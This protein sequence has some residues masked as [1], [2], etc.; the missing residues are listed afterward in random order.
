MVY[1]LAEHTGEMRSKDWSDVPTFP[2]TADSSGE[3]TKWV[4]P[5][6]FFDEL[7]DVLRTVAP[8]PGEQTL[9]VQ[10]AAL[11][12]AAGRFPDIR[13]AMDAA[14]AD[15]DRGL[16]KGYMRWEYNGLRTAN[17]WNRSLHNSEWGLDYYNRAATARSN[18]FENRPSETQY[19]YTDTD[20]DGA[21]LV[22][23]RTYQI[24]FAAGQLPPVDG[25]WSL[26]LSSARVR[27]SWPRPGG[28][29][30][31]RD[32]PG[33]AR[34]GRPSANMVF[35]L[36]RHVDAFERGVEMTISTSPTPRFLIS[37]STCSQYLAPHRPRSRHRPTGRGCRG[38]RRK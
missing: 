7:P 13:A 12:E 15:L 4:R 6:T 17:G 31:G 27:S 32:Q 37:V 1:P 25:F 8:L 22:G 11:L 2:A 34:A 26:T 5:E 24:S 19:L 18:M 16:I 20:S 23:E 38:A 14:V 33:P 9:Y 3:E 10:F 28:T 36:I 30:G 21:D 35:Q 29:V